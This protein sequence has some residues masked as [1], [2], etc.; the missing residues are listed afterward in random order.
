MVLIV[1]L[2]AEARPQARHC[3]CFTAPK[4]VRVCRH[5]QS[6]AGESSNVDDK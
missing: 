4:R 2:D 6:S 3:T 5:L 1:V